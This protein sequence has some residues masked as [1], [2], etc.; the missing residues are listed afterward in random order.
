VTRSRTDIARSAAAH[1]EAARPFGSLVGFDG[2]IDEIIA[3]V[4][5]RHAMTAEG[6]ARFRTITEF[7]ARIAAA[8]GKSTNIELVVE[9]ERWGGN[10]PL[11]AGALGALGSA[12]TYVGAV[13]KPDAPTELHPLYTEFASRCARVL[14]IAPPAHTDALEFEDGKVMLG[15]TAN[16]QRV[17]WDAIVAAVGLH[18]LRTL[19]RSTRLIGIVNWTMLGGVDGI[20]NGLARDILSL[21]PSLAQSLRIFIDLSDP[22]KRTDADL[23]AALANLRK[24]NTFVP[25]TLGL[26]L[27]EAERVAT[28]IGVT[29]MKDST[30]ALDQRVQAGAR[31]IRAALA[32]DCVVVHPREGAGAATADEVSWFW[33]PFTQNPK[34]STGAGDH[35]NGGF[36]FAQTLGM[37]LDECLATGCG[38]S[39]VYVRDA[40]SPTLA[41]LAEF[42]RELPDPISTRG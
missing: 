40:K 11:M 31:D 42:L 1:L 6:F 14:P 33:G 22:A 38:T 23:L 17:T 41:R 3:A 24:L 27:A 12:V 21:D 5:T 32:L 2:F 9:E 20:W 15:K 37:N 26:N 13:G 25:V 29:S 8:A 19:I 4:D 18:D 39:G 34:L 30:L 16:V 10:G 7:A 36:A 28:T 35:F